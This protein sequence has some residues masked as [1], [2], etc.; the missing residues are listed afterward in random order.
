MSK[1]TSMY[2]LALGLHAMSFGVEKPLGVPR[3]QMKFAP[4]KQD[5]GKTIST[6]KPK[7]KPFG[8]RKL[9]KKERKKRNAK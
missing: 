6:G 8:E 1:L 5:K 3:T 4:H 7:K 2:A 9:S